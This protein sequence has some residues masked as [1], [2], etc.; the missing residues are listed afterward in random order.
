MTA[1]ITVDGENLDQLLARGVDGISGL[2]SVAGTRG[3]DLLI[4]GAHG[5]RHVPGK[6][7]DAL[8]LA[9]P[10]WVRGVNPDGSLPGGTDSA[11]RVAFHGRVR[12]IVAMF[13]QG[14]QVTVRHTLTDGDA[15]EILA[16]VTD[17]MDMSVRGT[18][19]HTLGQVSV[20]LRCADPFWSDV[21]DSTGTATANSGASVTLSGFAGATA[22]MENLLVR[23]GPSTN[24]RITQPSTGVYMG[25]NGVVPSGGS[26]VVDTAA[27]RMYGEG[28]LTIV[29]ADYGQLY[30]GG[31]GT[32]RW[33]AL[34]PQAGGPVVALGHT[35]T[36][37]AT[38]IVTGRRRH[39]IA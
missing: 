26:L 16:E 29:P 20:G 38:A 15:R 22:P 37:S 31:P 18:G 33:F 6:R 5:E 35:S 11:A 14:Q 28:G 36:G 21:A 3:S 27:W 19:R 9:L 24:P 7:S 2:M 1:S 34:R 10:L 8:D 32:S 25:W 30:Y 4:P 12:A 39:R 23:F 17:V 13:P